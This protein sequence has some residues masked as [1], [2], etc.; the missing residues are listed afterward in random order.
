MKKINKLLATTALFGILMLNSRGFVTAQTETAIPQVP[1]APQAPVTPASPAATP[2][3]PATPAGPSL[4]VLPATPIPVIVEVED[5]QSGIP[6][7]TPTNEENSGGQ[8]EGGN[9]GVNSLVD[10]GDANTTGVI[11]NI[12]NLNVVE[13]A[14]GSGSDATIQ[15]TENGSGSNNSAI[16]VGTSDTTT[17]QDNSATIINNLNQ[18]S[19]TGDNTNSGNTGGSTTINTGNANTSGT[20]LNMVNTNA[21]GIMISEFNI[22]DDQTGD[23]ILDFPGNCIAGCGGSS[24]LTN[25]G[26][27]EGS[28]NDASLNLET[29]NATF[30]NNSAG[31]FNDMT[32]EANTGDNNSDRNTDSDAT[33][34]TGDANISANVANF[35]N[36][37]FAGNVYLGMVNIYGNLDGDIIFPDGFATCCASSTTAGISGNGDSSSNVANVTTSDEYLLGQANTADIQNNVTINAET[38]DNS[39]SRNT[40][41]N[42][43]VETGDAN[44]LAQVVN[45]ANNNIAGGDWW[46]VIV[47]EAGNWIGK[48]LGAP[49]GANMAAS[50]GT[51]I[52]VAP[53]GEMIVSNNGNGAN[54]DNA[55][56]INQSTT[57]T[58]VQNNDASIVNNVNLSANTGRNSASRNTGGDNSIT[59]GDANV[60]LNIINFVNNNVAGSGRLFVTLVNVFGSWNGDFVSPGTEQESQ[61]GTGGVAEIPQTQNSPSTGGSS[62]SSGSNSSNSSRNSI[63]QVLAQSTQGNGYSYSG[64]L[65]QIAS[66]ETD[67]NDEKDLVATVNAAGP[68]EESGTNL[69]VN[70]AWGLGLIPLYFIIRIVRRR[71]I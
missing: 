70:L 63:P 33:V 68:E 6:E 46:L 40:G 13:N 14:P 17:N 9:T 44:L 43:E 23:Y 38:G 49:E 20:I 56:L 26:N 30:Q 45:V 7:A 1:V 21:S 52:A 10:T 60:I 22:T 29:N 50:A 53:G 35:A 51:D 62:S 37:N 71:F 67:E 16:I 19:I 48:I 11:S 32:L 27:G 31:I 18:A 36:N 24:S 39:T 12:G 8:S 66:G 34:T 2:K 15:N 54:S 57:E 42:N 61:N 28:A 25:S 4:P 59:T 3:P 64:P 65:G 47:N 69:N 55:T 5:V 58:T 41:G